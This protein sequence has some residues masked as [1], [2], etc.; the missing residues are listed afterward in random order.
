M[1]VVHENLREVMNVAKVPVVDQ[2]LCTGCELCCETA[3][4]TFAINDDGVAEVVNP[5]GD[6][7]ETIQEA[8]D[9]C[10]AE[11]ISWQ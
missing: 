8:I 6:P 10:P 2:D 11:A 9:G 5:T 4:N 1:V 7:E 3:P